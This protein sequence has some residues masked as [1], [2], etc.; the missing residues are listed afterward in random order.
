MIAVAK[1]QL[2]SWAR[3]PVVGNH[4]ADRALPPEHPAIRPL[5][6]DE[7]KRREEALRAEHDAWFK[8]RITPLRQA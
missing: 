2:P 8:S 3:N 4:A 7:V 1:Q 5:S 6:P